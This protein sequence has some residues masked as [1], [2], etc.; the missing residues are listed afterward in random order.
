MKYLNLLETNKSPSGGFRWLLS[1]FDLPDTA[2][3]T[4]THRSVYYTQNFDAGGGNTVDDK[5][6]IEDDIAIHAAFGCNMTTFG[7]LQ[8]IYVK[9]IQGF[10]YFLHVAFCLNLTKRIK[11]IIVNLSTMSLKFVAYFNRFERYAFF[12]DSN[13][14]FASSNGVKFPSSIR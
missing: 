1:K 10:I 7:I 6:R 11:G 12:H 4:D 9:R 14:L 2:N 5:M 13:S 3:F 8:I